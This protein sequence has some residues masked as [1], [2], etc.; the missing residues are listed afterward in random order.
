MDRRAIVAALLLGFLAVL[1]PAFAATQD[2][3]TPAAKPAAGLDSAAS[4][5]TAEA[6]EGSGVGARPMLFTAWNAPWGTE[7][8]TNQLIVPCTEDDVRDTLYLT[9]DPGQDRPRLYALVCDLYIRA[10]SGDTLG[11]MWWLGGGALNDVNLVIEYPLA[12]DRTWPGAPVPWIT[13][14]F[15]G[16]KFDRT[17][18]SGHIRIAFAVP[19][20]Q[21]SAV[22]A[23]TRYA[24]ARMLIMRGKPSKGRCDQP[25][26]IEWSAADFTFDVKNA[27]DAEVPASRTGGSRFVTWN[28]RDGR[29]CGDFV[30]APGS[31]KPKTGR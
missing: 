20:D 11:P 26:C 18:S 9:F 8:A 6:P 24:F 7:R 3:G 22:K 27:P 2:G 13:N 15:G 16:A 29:A 5:T 19:S 1:P 14:G 25:I 21:P 12:N 23:G 17:R 28:S 31:W 10:Q 30:L 4:R